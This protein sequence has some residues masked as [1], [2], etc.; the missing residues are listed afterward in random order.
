M[1]ASEALRATKGSSS[2][3]RDEDEGMK[4]T[5]VLHAYPEENNL[6]WWETG[7]TEEMIVD[8]PL[9]RVCPPRKWLGASFH[10]V[11]SHG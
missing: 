8:H 11:I 4:A 6:L 9:R 5:I 3:K 7:A 1:Q 10:N 2:L